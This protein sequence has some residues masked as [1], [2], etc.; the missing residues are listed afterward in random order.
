MSDDEHPTVENKNSHGTVNPRETA[1]MTP[2]TARA[3]WMGVVV[4]VVGL[5]VTVAIPLVFV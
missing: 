3:V 1:P 2:F 4:F 5:L